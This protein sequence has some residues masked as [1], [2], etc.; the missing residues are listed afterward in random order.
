MSE[1]LLWYKKFNKTCFKKRWRMEDIDNFLIRQAYF[2]LFDSVPLGRK[3]E[4]WLQ[5]VIDSANAP[6]IERSG[7][8][9]EKQM[10]NLFQN[11][12]RFRA[13]SEGF[14]VKSHAF[15]EF[16]Q[17]ELAA[18]SELDPNLFSD[19]HEWT[20]AVIGMPYLNSLPD[21]RRYWTD[22]QKLNTLSSEINGWFYQKEG[23]ERD[24]LIKKANFI[25]G[26]LNLLAEAGIER[27]II[28]KKAFQ[29]WRI[30]K[31]GRAGTTS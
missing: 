18:K 9:V 17:Q 27:D 2:W 24:R 3:T 10:R 23:D 4:T 19:L 7:A 12:V 1:F 21:P 5:G 13:L 22:I 14:S 11:D 29:K 30:K 26:W 15:V 16:D 20:M 28:S 6:F 8:I 31:R 25:I